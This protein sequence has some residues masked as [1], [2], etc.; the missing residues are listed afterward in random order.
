[1]RLLLFDIDGTLL[2]LRGG[3]GRRVF[4]DAFHTAMNVDVTSALEGMSFSGRTDRNLVAEIA[5]RA[6][7]DADS[8]YQAWPALKYVM[9]DRAQ[10][11][12]VPDAVEVMPGASDLLSNL[13]RQNVTFGLV[14]GNV[15]SIA[16]RKLEAAGMDAY[17]TE[18]AFGCE[19]PDRNQLPPKAVVRLNSLHG[20]TYA[21]SDAVI[22]GDAPQD[23]ECARANGIRCVGVATG[24]HSSKQ[25]SDCGADAVLESF[26]DVD[27]SAVTILA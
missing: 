26:R 3:I 21:H 20:T 16:F 13:S 23:V 27:R 17:F 14:T 22:I 18:G 12:I 10:S 8:T 19:D 4:I 15:R 25:L 24:Q 9:E 1:M 7:I 11:W 2:R 6:G 5:T